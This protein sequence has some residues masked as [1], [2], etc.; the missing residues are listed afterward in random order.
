LD[1]HRQSQLRI[2]QLSFRLAPE[3]LQRG[4]TEIAVALMMTF[5]FEN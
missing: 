1:P 5:N 3:R 2:K 4:E